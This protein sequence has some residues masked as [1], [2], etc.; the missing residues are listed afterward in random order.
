MNTAIEAGAIIR[1]GHTTATRYTLP[2]PAEPPDSVAAALAVDLPVCPACGS[3]EYLDSVSGD[4]Q[5]GQ[6]RC[7]IKK[8][9]AFIEFTIWHGKPVPPRPLLA[10]AAG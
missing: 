4:G 9:G 1:H 2:T 5:M 8:C 7:A 6:R 3:H 10:A